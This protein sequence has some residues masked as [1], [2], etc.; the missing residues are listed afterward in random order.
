MRRQASKDCDHES[1]TR[2]VLAN[3]AYTVHTLI[4]H[5]QYK[6]NM[7]INNNHTKLIARIPKNNGDSTNSMNNS[8]IAKVLALVIEIK[9]K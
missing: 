8:T 4:I 7:K 5:E 6:N 2:T 3:Q 1:A 9:K